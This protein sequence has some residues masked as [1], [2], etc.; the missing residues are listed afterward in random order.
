M[1]STTTMPRD[2]A[3]DSLAF[4]FEARSL[5]IIGAS[6]DP[7]KQGGR[8]VRFAQLGNYQGKLYPINPHAAIVQGLPAYPSLSAVPEP[9]ECAFIALPAPAVE[10]AV[11]ECAANGVRAAVVISAGFAETGPEGQE[12]QDRIGAIARAAGMRLIGPNCMGAMNIGRGMF[13][14][15]L[16]VFGEGPA[17]RPKT[18]ALSLVSQSGAFGAHVF[19]LMRAEG[20][21][22][23]KW[24]TTGNQADVDVA[25]CIA[26]LSGD[27]ATKV[28]MVYMEGCRDGAK[29]MDALARARAARKPVVLL[30]SGRS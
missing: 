6:T 8:P 10:A 2:S 26:Y 30:K 29:L 22:F 14:T 3:T 24:M 15:F 27:P 7:L 4:F 9:V 25:D 17:G 23:A 11:R 20:E 18:G 5:A 21:G 28:I 12:A 1:D 19:E 13:A 16:S